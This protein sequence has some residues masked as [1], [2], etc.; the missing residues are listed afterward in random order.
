MIMM[1]RCIHSKSLISL[2][3]AIVVL[4]TISST[5]VVKAEFT[6]NPGGTID[7]DNPS[8]FDKVCGEADLANLCAQLQRTGLVRLL[9]GTYN[10]ATFTLFAPT[11]AAFASATNQDIG[12]T[13][14]QIKKTLR[15][16][17]TT[18]EVSRDN[19]PCDSTTLMTL[20]MNGQQLTST[21]KCDGTTRTEQNGRSVINGP[22]RILEQL[23]ETCNGYVI[24]IDN[25][26]GSG[27]RF[28]QPKDSRP[29]NNGHHKGY[30]GY[31]HQKY[32]SKTG[33][34]RWKGYN[35]NKQLQNELL[36]EMFG[37]QP[38]KNVFY[39]SKK[40]KKKHHYY[41]GSYKGYGK[42]GYQKGYK[43]GYGY[44]YK[45]YKGGYYW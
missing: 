38:S 3:C 41:Y 31:P 17:I 24:K 16:H 10:T 40:S 18:P 4:C 15:Y 1:T 11:N 5:V 29:K 43:G 37:V 23:P 13:T 30:K 2:F 20:T 27:I 22:P 9:D 42:G 32:K 14:E 33:H 19:L 7:S 26:M 12:Y 28:Y 36:Y 8:I 44:G 21:T 35:H 6:C 45:G 25:V 34:Q 39:H